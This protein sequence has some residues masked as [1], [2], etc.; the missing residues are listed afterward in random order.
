[1]TKLFS[2][3]IICILTATACYGQTPKELTEK[4]IDKKISLGSIASEELEWTNVQLDTS[5]IKNGKNLYI[6]SQSDT[7]TIISLTV[8][9]NDKD[10]PPKPKQFDAY[11]FYVK[12]NGK[13]YVDDIKCSAALFGYVSMVS[14]QIDQ[15]TTDANKRLWVKSNMTL[16]LKTDAELEQYFKQNQK[17]FELLLKDTK[18]KTSGTKQGVIEASDSLTTKNTLGKLLLTYSSVLRPNCIAFAI[19]D[20]DNR[21]VGFM[22]TADKSNLT[23]FG[24]KRFIFGK[25]LGNGWYVFRGKL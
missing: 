22:Y 9:G 13:W 14:A 21:R 15:I 4:L 1:M 11:L 19:T 24:Y 12:S 25:D 10:E 16:A 20:I 5:T 2:K 7:T 3:T 17:E 23:D 6:V 8:S 18:Q